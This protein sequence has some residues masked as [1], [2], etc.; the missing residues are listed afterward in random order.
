M[1]GFVLSCQNEKSDRFIDKQIILT[2]ENKVQKRYIDNL[3]NSTKII[4]LMN[5]DCGYC[6]SKLGAWNSFLSK[7]PF[8]FSKIIVYAYSSSA[9]YDL[10]EYL[11][12][13]DMSI[14]FPVFIDSLNSFRTM[15]MLN[16][17][18]PEVFVINQNNKVVLTGDPFRDVKLMKQ[19]KDLFYE[20]II[21]E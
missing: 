3:Q 4:Y 10:M 5:A 16:K 9:Q 6:L 14:Q 1:F 21:E 7:K 18:D 19:Y 12:E 20:E 13:S 2:N 15:N 17:D 11:I 8:L